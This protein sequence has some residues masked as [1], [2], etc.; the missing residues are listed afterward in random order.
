MPAL[1]ITAEPARLQV[2]WPLSIVGVVLDPAA[3][4]RSCLS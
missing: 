1:V 4:T 3:A 2:N